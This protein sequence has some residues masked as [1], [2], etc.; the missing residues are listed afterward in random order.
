MANTPISAFTTEECAWKQVSIKILGRK[1]TGLRSFEF[2]KGIS[3]E[4]LFA[5]G[6]NPIDIQSGNKNPSG[7]LGVLKYEYDLMNDA[8]QAAG[9]DDIL[10]VPHYLISITCLFKKYQTSPIR[11]ITALGV[12]FTE[13]TVGMQQN[14]NMTEVP[15]PF[16][17]MQRVTAKG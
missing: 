6:D 4:L 16:I 3:K 5:A 10:E 12:A 15:L 7:Q 17:C 14:A 9:Y 11:T 13:D 1:I 2:K 8:A